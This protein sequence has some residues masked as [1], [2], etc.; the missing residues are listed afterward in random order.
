MEEIR[1]RLEQL[2]TDFTKDIGQAA[3]LAGL[4]ELRVSYLGKKGGLTRILRAMGQL[5]PAQR[6][7]VG[8]LANELRQIS[9]RQPLSGWAARSRPPGWPRKSWM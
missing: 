4:A 2:A 9:W 8:Q 5:D 1:S 6:P 3:D 7:L